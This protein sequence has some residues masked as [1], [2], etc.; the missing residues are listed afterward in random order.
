MS[1]E[2]RAPENSRE[3]RAGRQKSRLSAPDPRRPAVFAFTLIEM[4]VV[5]VIMGIIAGLAVPALKNLGQSDAGLSASRQLLDDV[6]RARQL[7][8]A[9]HTTVYMVFVPT[10]FWGNN[11]SAFISSLKTSAQQIAA[12]NLCDKQL[13]GYTFISYGGVG[14]QPGQHA[15]HYL[16]PWQYLPEGTFVAEQKFDLSYGNYA[17]VNEATGATFPISQFNYAD[18]IPFPTEDSPVGV[19]LPYVAFNYL[20]QLTTAQLSPQPLQQD[21]YIPLAHGSV[22]PAMDLQK[23]YTFNSP[24]VSEVPPGNSTNSSFNVVHIDW[25]TGR[26][27]LEYQKVQ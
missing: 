17:I 8:I 2:R 3:L 1:V 20:G 16:A 21:Q 12:T 26:A 4:L 5:I 25:L 6:G 24:D 11:P 18:N 10:N 13:T 14:D 19:D 15:W 23:N 22:L 9:N 27:T 7:A